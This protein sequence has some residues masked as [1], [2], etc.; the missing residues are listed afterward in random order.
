MG[1]SD[2]RPS[3]CT[4]DRDPTAICPV[5]RYAHEADREI[6]VRDVLAGYT[7]DPQSGMM[8]L[9]PSPEEAQ[10]EEDHEYDIRTWALDAASRCYAG[11]GGDFPNSVIDLAK[12]FEEYLRGD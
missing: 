6:G 10:A 2:P 4:K 1:T 9:D 12:R 3:L 7:R 5:H 8:T 11:G